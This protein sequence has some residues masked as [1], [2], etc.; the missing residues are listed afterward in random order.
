[1]NTSSLPMKPANGGMPAMENSS[2]VNSA[3]IHGRRLREAGEIG[4][5]LRRLGRRGAWRG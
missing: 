2:I 4:D 1:M 3:A 5:C